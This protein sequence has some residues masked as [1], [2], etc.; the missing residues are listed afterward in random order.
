VRQLATTATPVKPYKSQLEDKHDRMLADYKRSPLPE[1]YDPIDREE[2]M[3][4]TTSGYKLFTIIYKPMKSGVWPVIVHRSC[5]PAQHM[6]FEMNGRELAKRGFSYVFQYCR[7]IG[8]SEG[9]WEPNIY[10]RAD[11]LDLVNWLD[12]QSW[13][14]CIGIYGTSYAAYNGWIMADALPEKVKSLCLNHYGVDRYCS[15]YEGGLFRHDIMTHWAMRNAGVHIDADYLD[16]C[17]Y[18]PQVEVDEELWDCHLDWYRDW[19][20]STWEDSPYWNSGVWKQLKEIPQKMTVPVY[21]ME[22]WFDHHLG[23]ALRTFEMLGDE[24]ARHSWLDIGCWNHGFAPC[25]DGLEGEH[26][27]NSEVLNLLDWFTLTLLE[28]QIPERQVRTYVINEDRWDVHRNWPP[29]PESPGRLYLDCGRR[30]LST[31]EPETEASISYIYDPE[32]PVMSNSGEALLGSAA[33]RGSHFQPEP[34]YRDDVISFL[35]QPMQEDGRILGKL[36][37]VLYVSSDCP[38][39]SF[40][41]KIIENR[42]DGSS[43]NIRS[44]IATIGHCL[45]R[46]RT[47]TPGS[48][49]ELHIHFWDVDWAIKKGSQIRVDISSSDFPQYS[50]HGNFAKPWAEQERSQKATQTLYSGAEKRSAL[51]IPWSKK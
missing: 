21:I 15:L 18:R 11:G 27:H 34:D 14:D 39:T 22:G 25:V 6:I 13:V 31:D 24:A 42:S 29:V 23:S 28:K 37:V 35:S 20:T 16:S 8:P 4:P 48:V 17:R 45:G 26:F 2:F 47:Y 36:E 19:V 40:S 3:F 32:D 43:L 46:D 51:I 12:K 50:I 5:Y 33:Q 49:Q 30:A 41:A 1:R 44:S 7:G 10:D 38:D 9:E